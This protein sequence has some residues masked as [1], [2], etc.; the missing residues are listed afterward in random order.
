MPR[1]YEGY[2]FILVVIDEVTNFL[3]TIPIYQQ[4]SEEIRDVLMENVLSRY[5]IPECM[6]MDQ[7]SALMSTLINY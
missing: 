3:V 4:R 5:S 1:F 6:V 2:K 7:E